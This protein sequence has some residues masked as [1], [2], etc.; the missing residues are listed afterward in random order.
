[1]EI[2][3]PLLTGLAVS[4]TAA[5][6]SSD[7]ELDYGAATVCST[8]TFE[9]QIA[10]LQLGGGKLSAAASEGLA[11]CGIG[12]GELMHEIE[13]KLKKLQCAVRAAKATLE[14]DGAARHAL[15]RE[16][17][18]SISGE[19]SAIASRLKDHCS[20]I[21]R[22]LQHI[23]K[24]ILEMTNVSYDINLSVA[25]TNAQS[26]IIALL[27][28]V[29]AFTP[30]LLQQTLNI[31]AAIVPTLAAQTAETTNSA[32]AGI[33]RE[34]ENKV[35][36]KECAS[37]CTH[38]DPGRALIESVCRNI[39]TYNSTCSSSI[40]DELDKLLVLIN[41]ILV[42]VNRAACRASEEEGKQAACE[43]DCTISRAAYSQ[44][45]QKRGHT[46]TVSTV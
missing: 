43:Q 23:V 21:A 16:V 39:S 7:S 36:M 45:A 6:S 33:N 41:T 10:G 44:T 46:R 2:A 38:E 9:N 14:D 28:G 42:D 19:F 24:Q 5:A 17:G 32:I 12:S 37:D 30:E 1:M 29:T 25:V 18:D 34:I 4:L 35:T 26:D 15:S 31:V 11:I 3:L 13:M 40:A 20:S 27:N 8:A 22:Y